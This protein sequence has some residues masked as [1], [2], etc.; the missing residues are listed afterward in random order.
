MV[1]PISIA[2]IASSPALFTT[3]Q[4]SSLKQARLGWILNNWQMNGILTLQTGTPFSII[5]IVGNNIIQRANFKTGFTGSIETS[6]STQD[7]LNGFFNVNRV[8]SFETDSLE[9]KQHGNANQPKL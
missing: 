5:D 4:S 3:C 8:C 6:G 1:H 2:A 9:W 7:R